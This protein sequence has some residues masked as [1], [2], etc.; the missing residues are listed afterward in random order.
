MKYGEM[1]LLQLLSRR[2]PNR[3][4]SLY[5]DDVA[6]FIKPTEDEMNLTMEILGKFG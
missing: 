4:I 5:A 1:E 2:N 3:H 6:L